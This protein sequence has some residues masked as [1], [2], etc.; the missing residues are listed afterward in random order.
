M[1]DG[2][3]K[4]ITMPIPVPGA[5]EI[6]VQVAAAPI[7][8]SD[9]L[10]TKGIY[11]MEA[12]FPKPCGFEGS[13]TVVQ[14]GEGSGEQFKALLGKRVS[15]IKS[16]GKFVY[17]SWGEFIM[18]PA[19]NVNLL[20]KNSSFEQGCMSVVNPATCVAMFDICADDGC[21]AII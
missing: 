20:H 19:F 13:G 1:E 21:K 17:G 10:Y 16:S 6:L 14:V 11:P 8:P 12:D 2:S 7:N 4:C 9:E 15:F 18:V 3:L 5:N